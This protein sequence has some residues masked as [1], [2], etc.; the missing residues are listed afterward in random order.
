MRKILVTAILVVGSIVN[1][2]A[3][4]LVKGGV[5]LGLNNSI[6]KGDANGGSESKLGVSAGFFVELPV[7][8]KFSIT[9]ELLYSEEGSKL[10]EDDVESDF[11]FSYLNIPVMFKYYVTEKFNIQAG[12]Q[13]GLLVKSKLERLSSIGELITVDAEQDL[14][15]P[16]FNFGINVGLGYQITEKFFVDARYNYGLT[17]LSEFLDI[18]SSVFNIS[19]GYRLD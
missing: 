6:F 9:P 3:Q 15:T 14:D 2:S 12:P 11:I 17:D 1:L 5:K 4:K 8:E 19:L 16:K 7:T 13:V 10:Q 18:Q